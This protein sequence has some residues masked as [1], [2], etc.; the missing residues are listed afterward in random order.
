MS[1]TQKTFLYPSVK[2]G[3]VQGCVLALHSQLPFCVAPASALWQCL[4]SAS[5]KLQRSHWATVSA[6]TVCVM[7]MQSSFLE[8]KLPLDRGKLF[9]VPYIKQ[10]PQ[11]PYERKTVSSAAFPCR[12]LSV[13]LGYFENFHQ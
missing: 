2:I 3:C 8:G 10:E 9:T 5:Q 12:T 4:R 7:L 13:V 1:P 6:G 11:V